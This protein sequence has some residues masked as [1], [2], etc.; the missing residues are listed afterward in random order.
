MQRSDQDIVQD[1][2]YSEKQLCNTYTLAATEAK[3]EGIR[4]NFRDILTC[5]LDVQNQVFQTMSAK[6]WYQPEQADINKVQQAKTKFS[7]FAMQ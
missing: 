6:G 1:L 5:E 2:L 4:N 3:T 7:S